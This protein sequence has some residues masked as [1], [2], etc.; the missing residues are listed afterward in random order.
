MDKDRQLRL[1]VLKPQMLAEESLFEGAVGTLSF[2]SLPAHITTPAEK[3][4]LVWFYD[5]RLVDSAPGRKLYDKIL[6]L[7]GGICPMCGITDA[8][9][10]DH[11]LPKSRFPKLA[12]TPLNL[13]AACRDCNMEK[14]A[15]VGAGN[16]SPYFDDWV[17]TTQWLVASIAD[18]SHPEI[19]SFAVA[20]PAAWSNA[21]Y[22]SV[23]TF[24]EDAKLNRRYGVQGVNEYQ[25]YCD[26][27]H[28]DFVRGG[29]EEVKRVLDSRFRGTSKQRL[30]GWQAATYRAWLDAADSIDW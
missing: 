4:D 7:S 27:F 5:Q 17:A 14:N 29:I 26:G 25:N 18:T 15:A 28:E 6:K 19:M 12:I 23:A 13:S 21:E 30:N 8:S 16:L 2:R 11:C 9:T 10:L 3:E 24:F 22:D 20:R 1:V